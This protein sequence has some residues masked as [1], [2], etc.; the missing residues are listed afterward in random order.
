MPVSSFP[1]LAPSPIGVRDTPGKTLSAPV[2]GGTTPAVTGW[3][4]SASSTSWSR[5]RSR[6]WLV[7]R[8]WRHSWA[9]L[10][11]TWPSCRTGWREAGR[12][13]LAACGTALG[14]EP[15]TEVS[16]GA[17]W[18]TAHRAT[19]IAGQTVQGTS[20]HPQFRHSAEGQFSDKSQRP[21]GVYRISTKINNF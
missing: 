8:W 13:Y 6:C 17:I 4:S 12:I 14:A 11:R 3:S 18:W 9:R 7:F 16:R 10:G 1:S 15:A 21:K 5:C 19:A 2:T 20:H